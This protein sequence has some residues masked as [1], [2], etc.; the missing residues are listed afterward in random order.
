MSNKNHLTYTLGS[1]LAFMALNA[2]GGGYYAMSGAEGVPID[3][4]QGSPFSSY[5]IPGLVLFVVVDG[6][7]LMAAV[8]VFVHSRIAKFATVT[9]VIIVFA[10]LLVQIAI[11]GYVSWM[12]P[13]TGAVALIIL[14]LA[15]ELPSSHEERRVSTCLNGL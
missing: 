8:C 9:A 11:I 13:T 15:L 4:L 7:S 1:L 14:L 6:S 5:F 3:W 12:Q 2:F 10:W